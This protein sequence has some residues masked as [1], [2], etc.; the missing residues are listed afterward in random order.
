METDEIKVKILKELKRA[1]G[2]EIHIKVLARS[3]GSGL[4]SARH[5]AENLVN[6]GA[7]RKISTSRES[8]RYYI[9]SAGMLAA[10]KAQQDRVRPFTPLKPRRDKELIIQRI[11]QER[12]SIPS[13]F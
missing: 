7:I 6:S 11:R 2:A 13:I 9:P 12:E 5:V 8:A 4:S 10:E 3:V 1:D